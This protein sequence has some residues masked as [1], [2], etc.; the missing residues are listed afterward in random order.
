MNTFICMYICFL[1]NKHFSCHLSKSEIIIFPAEKFLQHQNKKKSNSAVRKGFI[2]VTQHQYTDTFYTPSPHPPMQTHYHHH[3]HHHVEKNIFLCFKPLPLLE[4]GRIYMYS[5]SSI[6]V[7]NTLYMF[8]FWGFFLAQIHVIFACFCS[9]L[10]LQS[11][12]NRPL[13]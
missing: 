5:I 2:Q 10:H 3:H 8:G 11:C 7:D 13:L 1:S 4:E 9:L 12:I 6:I